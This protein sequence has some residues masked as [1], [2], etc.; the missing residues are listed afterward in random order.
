MLNGFIYFEAE[1]LISWFQNF[2]NQMVLWKE[3]SGYRVAKRR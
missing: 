2:G 1:D 3:P